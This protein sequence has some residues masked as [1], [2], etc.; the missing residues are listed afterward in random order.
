[1]SRH[2]GQDELKVG[3][4]RIPGCRKESLGFLARLEVGVVAWIRDEESLGSC[5]GLALAGRPA[6][7]SH[8]LPP[9]P[10]RT[11]EENR[12]SKS[13]KTQVLRQKKLNK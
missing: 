8:A 7:H 1:M 12:K 5:G 10:S 4:H 11:G 2:A 9:A 3:L 13:K 6:P